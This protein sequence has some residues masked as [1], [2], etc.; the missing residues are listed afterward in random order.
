METTTNSLHFFFWALLAGCKGTESFVVQ[1]TYTFRVGQ[2][3]T[4]HNKKNRKHQERQMR[5]IIIFYKKNSKTTYIFFE[6]YLQ[7]IIFVSY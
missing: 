5:P 6:N 2:K 1:D 3:P 7:T 4:V